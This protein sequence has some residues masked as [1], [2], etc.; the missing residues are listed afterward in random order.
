VHV[1]LRR[2][3]T[4]TYGIRRIVFPLVGTSTMFR[5]STHNSGPASGKKMPMKR[6]N[7]S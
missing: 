5:R 6:P 4:Y 1:E 3:H 2:Q 7:V